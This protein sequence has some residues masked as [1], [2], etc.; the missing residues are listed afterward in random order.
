MSRI[1]RKGLQGGRLAVEGFQGGEC[2]VRELPGNP[3]ISPIPR[4]TDRWPLGLGVFSRGLAQLLAGLG[5]IQD[6]VDDLEGEADM[7]AEIGERL[8][9]AGVQLALMPPRRTAQQ[10]RAEVLRSWM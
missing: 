4:W 6:V 9:L 10:S 8:E 3:S 5:D 7:V 2:L 1:L